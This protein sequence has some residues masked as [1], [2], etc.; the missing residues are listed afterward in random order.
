M[1]LSRAVSADGG[2]APLCARVSS[3]SQ[4]S[5][6][7][8]PSRAVATPPHVLA[9]VAR[10]GRLAPARGAV[11][12]DLEDHALEGVCRAAGDGEGALGVHAYGLYAR[13]Q[14]RSLLHTAWVAL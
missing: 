5:H 13:L 2:I 14:V 10:G 8:A 3:M 4:G 12:A 9:V 11:F 7:S 1:A 6:T